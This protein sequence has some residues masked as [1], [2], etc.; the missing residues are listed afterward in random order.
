MPI[1]DQ[2]TYLGAEISKTALGDARIAK[3][4]G[5][6]KAHV[7]KMDAILIDSHLDCINRIIICTQLNVILPKPEY[8]GEVWEGN[9][10]F[11][12]QPETAVQHLRLNKYYHR[13]LKY[14]E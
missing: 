9:A 4:V 7:G 8:A 11:V 10:K 5:K 14:N 1:A 2:Y 3:V 13:M 6:G 12:K